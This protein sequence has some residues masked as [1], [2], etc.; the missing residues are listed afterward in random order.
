M[1]GFAGARGHPWGVSRPGTPTQR[2][3]HCC[4]LSVPREHALGIELLPE[5]GRD[6]GQ[7]FKGLGEMN[8]EGLV[9]RLDREGRA[10]YGADIRPLAVGVVLPL[11]RVAEHRHPRL[12][13]ANHAP[14][15][16]PRPATAP[17]AVATKALVATA[18]ALLTAGDQATSITN[19][20]RPKLGHVRPS[21]NLRS[22]MAVRLQYSEGVAGVPEYNTIA[23]PF[24]SPGVEMHL[25][26]W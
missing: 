17:A 1:D 25:S 16:D 9:A 13:G 24:A 5:P 22:Q 18:A 14:E 2:V 6:G 23:S 19:N 26:L 8:D 10:D 20:H 3:S 15:H 11:A 12:L 4:Y 21:R 7:R